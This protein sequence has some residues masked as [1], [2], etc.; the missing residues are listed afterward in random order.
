[1]RIIFLAFLLPYVMFFFCEISPRL[2][3]FK[4][5]RKQTHITEQEKKEVANQ[6]MDIKRIF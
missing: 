3:E 1:M 6:Y 2:P 5:Q 4:D